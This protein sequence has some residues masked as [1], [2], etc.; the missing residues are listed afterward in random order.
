PIL[1]VI[2]DENCTEIFARSLWGRVAANDEFLFVDT[3]KLDPRTASA[4]RFVN[5]VA[6]FGDDPFQAAAFHL[7]EQCSRVVA[8]LGGVTNW[9]AR[10]RAKVFEKVFPRSICDRAHVISGTLKRL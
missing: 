9:V 5:R 2:P 10:I 8:D 4:P 1:L 3:L 6:L 7:L